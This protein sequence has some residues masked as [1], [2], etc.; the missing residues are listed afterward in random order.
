MTRRLESE[1]THY[2]N[3]D[4]DIL[5]PVPLDDLVRGFGDAAL[6]LY[7]GGARRKYEAHVELASSRMSSSADH[8]IIA[9]ARLVQRLPP[10]HRKVWNSAKLREFNIGIQ[11]GFEPHGFELHL[12]Q[13]TVDAI[14]AVQGTLAVT[15]Y[16]PDLSVSRIRDEK[17]KL[18]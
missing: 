9:L 7:V 18:T 12:Q 6:I 4:L 14:S 8:T 13:R 15:V 11:A 17:R 10:R 2:L 1:R 5:A 3:V 16:A